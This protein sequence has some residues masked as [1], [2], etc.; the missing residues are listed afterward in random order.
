MNKKTVALFLTICFFRN[1]QS[2][3][4]YI[5]VY[6]QYHL[7]ISS[8]PSPQYFDPGDLTNGYYVENV[9]SDIKD[10]SIASGFK[11]GGA[12]G[13]QFND[14][15][16]I[17]TGIDY[18]GTKRNIKA[19]FAFFAFAATTKWDYQSI[20][21]SPSLTAKKTM[22]KSSLIIKAGPIIGMAWLKNTVQA[23]DYL[24][25]TY[26]LEKH[27]TLGYTMGIEYDSK[28]SSTLSLLIE[29]GLEHS[30]YTPSKAKLKAINVPGSTSVD[31]QSE[32]LKKIEYV[33]QVRNLDVFPTYNNYNI[34]FANSYNSNPAKPE[35]RIK[36]SINF[37]TAYLGIG[38]K[39]NIGGNEKK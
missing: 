33:K 15:L 39:Y 26:L 20:Q 7:A 19:D 16:G 2:Q 1:A 28:L 30:S 17:E 34:Y 22:N 8:E 9:S 14:V 4:I 18:F 31:D 21:A 36:Q 3:Q 29:C 37:N 25:R 24:S 13:Y 5:K 38:F 23:G 27:L 6:T 11:Y 10:F 32:Y 12:V 35:I